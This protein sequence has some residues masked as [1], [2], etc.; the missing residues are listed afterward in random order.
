MVVTVIAT[1]GFWA[2]RYV[3][4]QRAERAY[5]DAYVAWEGETL[6]SA[7][8]CLA[9]RRLYEAEIAVPFADRKKAAAAYLARAAKMKRQLYLLREVAQHSEDADK[10]WA[11]VHDCYKEAERVA[12]SP[13]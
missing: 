10:N 8:L 6:P 5:L 3:A 11:L 12:N 13:P 4:W 1:I 9:S 7:E 2:T